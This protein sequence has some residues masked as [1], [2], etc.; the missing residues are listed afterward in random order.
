[1]ELPKEIRV[2]TWRDNKG[3]ELSFDLEHSKRIW[4]LNRKNSVEIFINLTEL[5]DQFIN[6]ELSFYPV[7]EFVYLKR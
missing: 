4:K 5:F 3:K 2:I 6:L 1:M 7:K